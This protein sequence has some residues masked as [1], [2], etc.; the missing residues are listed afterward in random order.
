MYCMVDSVYISLF[1]HIRQH[2]VSKSY[3]SDEHFL[4]DSL[5]DWVLDQLGDPSYD[6]LSIKA[7]SFKRKVGKMIQ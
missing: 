3:K 5:F 7:E 6:T 4:A 1:R 2:I